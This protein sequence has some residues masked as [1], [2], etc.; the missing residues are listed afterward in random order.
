MTRTNR[1]RKLPELLAEAFLNM[2]R[3]YHAAAN[4]L[5]SSGGDTMSPLYFLYTHTIELVFKAYLRSL[6]CSV[7]RIHALQSLCARCQAQGLQVN[8]DLANVIRLLESENEVHGFRYFAFISTG[9]PEIGYLRQVVNDLMIT[10]TE[11]INKKPGEDLLKGAVLKFTVGKPV[12]K[13]PKHTL[14]RTRVAQLEH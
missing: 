1:E 2:A 6:G 14:V 12:K 3:Q 5:L 10:V 11:E 7:P 9:I 8:V 13:L 4:T